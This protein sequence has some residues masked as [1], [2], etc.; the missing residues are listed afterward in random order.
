MKFIM[1]FVYPRH[2]M[3]SKM[4]AAESIQ[5]FFRYLDIRLWIDKSI[6]IFPS[7]RIGNTDD[8]SLLNS[9]MFVKDFF[10]FVWIN[11]VATFNDHIFFTIDD[12]KVSVLIHITKITCQ[13]PTIF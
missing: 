11:V 5:F 7:I 8:R 4:F 12:V 1:K 2:F 9:F 10:D 6:D 13:K 3:S